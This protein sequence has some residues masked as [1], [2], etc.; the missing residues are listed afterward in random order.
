M[1]K[2]GRNCDLAMT[3]E[4]IRLFLGPV[5]GNMSNGAL[6]MTP[7]TKALTWIC[8]VSLETSSLSLHTQPQI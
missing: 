5:A 7:L 6:N 1:V 2:F 3:R 8:F 4:A